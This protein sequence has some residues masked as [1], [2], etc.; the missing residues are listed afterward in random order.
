MR[1]CAYCGE[2]GK[3]TR[4]E[5]MP[6]FLSDNRPKYRTIVDHYRGKVRR[7][8][9]TPVKGVCADCN[10]VTLS[11]LDTYVSALDRDYFLNIIGFS[12]KITF[13]YHFDRLLRWLLKLSYNDDRTR[14]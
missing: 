6:L 11:A 8:R 2:A 12:P 1:V 10:G 7:G 5:V 14:A 9:I 4:E 3:P 13:R